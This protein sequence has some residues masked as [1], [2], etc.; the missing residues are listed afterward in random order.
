MAVAV[1]MAASDRRETYVVLVDLGD[2]PDE[3]QEVPRDLPHLHALYVDDDENGFDRLAGGQR[4][5]R[6]H[7]REAL[8]KGRGGQQRAGQGHGN[9]PAPRCGA[10][11]GR[12]WW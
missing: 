5:L 1:A 2:V 4:L 12:R 9:V 6:K 10:A 8:L 11:R 7:V 3:R